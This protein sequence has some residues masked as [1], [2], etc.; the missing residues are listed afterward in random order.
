MVR[1]FGQP[2]ERGFGLETH[3][4]AEAP[5]E[6]DQLLQPRIGEASLHCHVLELLAAAFQRLANCMYSADD[7]HDG[8][9]L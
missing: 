1:A 3:R 6:L 4:D 8:S 2:V 9:P 7:F 5:A